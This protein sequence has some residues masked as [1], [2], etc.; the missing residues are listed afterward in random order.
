MLSNK[1]P[2]TQPLF[3]HITTLVFTPQEP[4]SFRP[5]PR[6]PIPTEARSA[7]ADAA[8]AAAGGAV[9]ATSSDFVP[10]EFVRGDAATLNGGGTS[11]GT[12]SNGGGDG[13]G[14]GA[15]AG[16]SGRASAAAVGEDRVGAGGAG[17]ALLS[18]PVSAQQAGSGALQPVPLPMQP[19]AARPAAFE[20]H[21]KEFGSRFLEVNFV[22]SVK[23][24]ETCVI[25]HACDEG[26][27]SPFRLMHGPSATRL[28]EVFKRD[29]WAYSA[30]TL[31]R[32]S[33]RK[34]ELRLAKQREILSRGSPLP[35]TSTR[36]LYF[37]AD[38]VRG[39]PHGFFV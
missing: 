28:V 12:G 15:A 19:R 14:G 7:A 10:I 24:A 1:P 16:G 30:P 35:S 39:T 31:A 25:C 13:G 32:C 3:I 37:C 23:Y 21:T 36:V 2:S 26:G 8:V 27:S 6:P 34:S 33:L 29:I 38:D 4:G 18:S 17:A 11:G 20:R 9:S 22:V 5:P